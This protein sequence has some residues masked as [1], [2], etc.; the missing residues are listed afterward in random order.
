MTIT[1]LLS[2]YGLDAGV[3]ISID[4]IIDML[5]PTDLPFQNGFMLGG[6]PALS[7]FPVDNKKMEWQDDTL[8]ESLSTINEGGTYSNS[9]VTLTV[10]DGTR[11]KEG[12]VIRIDT[13]QLY[14]SSVSTH[15]LTVIRAFAGS[16]ATT[17][18]DG[19]RVIGLGQA[20]AEGSD[21]IQASHKDR[22]RRYNMTSIFGPRE[23]K[24]TGT[25][26]VM[27]KYGL[28]TGG[29]WA[30]QINKEGLELA[31]MVERQI[32]YGN[33]YD[34]G[35]DQRTMGGLMYYYTTNVSAATALT[36]DSV[37]D[38]LEAMYNAGATPNQGWILACNLK[39]KRAV[40]GIGTV[41]IMRSDSGR[42]TV[43]EYFDTDVGRVQFNVSRYYENKDANL[44]TQDQVSIGDLR[45]WQLET[46]AKTGDSDKMMLVSEKTLRVKRERH[47]A[48]FNALTPS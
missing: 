36:E 41:E 14:V 5:D 17:H 38:Q 9:D 13:E 1:G 28:A 11:F 4:T 18:A 34:D 26:Q 46:L 19:A 3:P 6:A 21:A 33:R 12:D 39:N 29:E 16:T 8:L 42:G 23:I 44:Y 30:Y 43:V 24:A 10:V 15:N 31:K 7:R 22:D 25:E 47:G 27:P 45:P 2:S 35:A 40:S 20:L 32:I 37:A 48:A